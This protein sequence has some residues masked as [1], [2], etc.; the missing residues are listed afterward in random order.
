M[1]T[2]TKSTKSTK[3]QAPVLPVAAQDGQVKYVVGKLPRNGLHLETKHGDGGTAGT[4]KA[5]VKALE[6]G[7]KTL[8]ELKAITAVNN[9]KGF[10]SYAVRN[11]W[12]VPAPQAG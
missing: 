1:S 4:Y 7:P 9:D 3:T 10:A 5:I 12:V 2:V 11:H 6:T 8:A